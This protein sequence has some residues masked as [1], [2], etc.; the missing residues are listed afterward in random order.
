[1]YPLHVGLMLGTSLFQLDLHLCLFQAQ[2]AL[3]S[4]AGVAKWSARTQ[5]GNG[6]TRQGLHI[7]AA[8]FGVIWKESVP[9]SSHYGWLLG[10]KCCD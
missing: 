9:N 2:L 4:S 6:H 5:I 1:M 10:G 3:I 8:L 7:L